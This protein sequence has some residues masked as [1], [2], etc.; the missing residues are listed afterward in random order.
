M[1]ERDDGGTAVSARTDLTVP[2]RPAQF[3]R[4]VLGEVGDRLVGRFADCLASQLARGAGIT[5]ETGV[6]G[7]AAA[8]GTAGVTEAGSSAQKPP[9]LDLLRI[10]GLPLAERAALAAARAA[11]AAAA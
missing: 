11:L 9:A 7:G 2:G 3:G 1:S 10:A 5:E 4:G 8:A 6:A